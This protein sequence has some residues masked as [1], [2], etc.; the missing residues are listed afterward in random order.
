MLKSV[1]DF[2]NSTIFRGTIRQCPYGPGFVRVVNASVDSDTVI[3]FG[4]RQVMPNGHYK[5]D[6]KMYNK[7]DENVL[8]LSLILESSW[9]LSKLS[10]DERF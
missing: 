2:A 9:R 5:I 8:T 7:K 4:S 6:I 3:N 10:G 1:I